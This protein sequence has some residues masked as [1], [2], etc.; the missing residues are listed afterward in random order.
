MGKRK[1]YLT[2]EEWVASI[3]TVSKERSKDPSTQVSAVLLNKEGR[4]ISIGYNGMPNGTS[5]DEV[6]W[7]REGGLL[8]SK[9]GM[10]CHAELNCIANAGLAN[11]SDC[12]LWVSLFPCNECSKLIIQFGIKHLIYLDD[13]YKDTDEVKLSKMLLDNANVNYEEYVPSGRKISFD[14]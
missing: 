4:I 14:V 10:V 1:N 2:R 9:Y 11:L 6:S 3:I 8:E 7:D 13:K 12:T 5:D